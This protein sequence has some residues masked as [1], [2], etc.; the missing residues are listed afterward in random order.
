VAIWASVRTASKWLTRS[1]EVTISLPRERRSSMVPASTSETYMMALRGEY[2]MAIFVCAG[3]DGF[4]L[5][6]SSCQ[7][8][9]SVFVPGRVSSLPDSMRWTSFFGSPVA[10]MK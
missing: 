5:D 3:E 4:E 1:A 2:C 7:E 10:G 6:S 9:Y 8:E